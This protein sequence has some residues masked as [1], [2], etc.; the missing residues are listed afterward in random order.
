[1]DKSIC[2]ILQQTQNGEEVFLTDA[3]L[4]NEII[5]DKSLGKPKREYKK[6]LWDENKSFAVRVSDFF[7]RSF[8]VVQ[9]KWGARIKKC[10]EQLEFGWI[11]TDLHQFF[12]R[13]KT[14]K[15]CRVRFC[16]V[17]QWRRSLMW[18][19]R[20]FD[21]FPRIHKDYPKMRYIFL[22]LT[23]ANVP[24]TE[25]RSTVD[26]MGKAWKRLSE[27]KAFPALGFVRSLEVTKEKDLFETIDVFDEKKK[28]FVKQLVK[29]KKLL[30]KARPDYCHPHFHIL[31]AVPSSYFARDYLSKDDWAELWQK[32]LRADYKPVVDIR[33]VRPKK[34]KLVEGLKVLDVEEFSEKQALDAIMAAVTETVKYS[35]KPADM[36]DDA[37]WFLEVAKQLNNT[38]AVA[39]GGIFKKYFSVD[40]DDLVLESKKS[41]NQGGIYFGFRRDI[42]RY[43]RVHRAK[44]EAD[45]ILKE[46]EINHAVNQPSETDKIARDK[47]ARELAE[48]QRVD[49]ARKAKLK[50]V[51]DLE[52]HF[53][54]GFSFGNAVDH[55]DYDDYDKY[56]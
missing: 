23:V 11:E 40:D 54:D 8:D 41:E 43:Q 33:I 31:L 45:R 28:K 14:A 32:S 5:N 53:S 52:N 34:E 20:F 50:P 24:I 13:L 6:K 12:L 46:S 49:L 39:L 47:F 1:M 36:V 18:A 55:D 3:L 51:D 2:S 16:P 4:K 30:R 22:T 9:Q 7:T 26:I 29:P 25:L 48:V 35:V 38:R 27:R 44:I 10:A 17:C 15:F 56:D 37:S 42:K 21:A 19:S